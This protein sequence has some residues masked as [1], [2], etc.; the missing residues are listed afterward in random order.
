MAA[1]LGHLS[2]P[3]F[4]LELKLQLLQLVDGRSGDFLTSIL[5]GTDSLQ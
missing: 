3:A 5:M 2:S 4:R 1:E